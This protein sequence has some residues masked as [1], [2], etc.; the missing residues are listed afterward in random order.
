MKRIFAI[1]A[2]VVL[3]SALACISHNV[4]H[5]TPSEDY[6]HENLPEPHTYKEFV[7]VEGHEW[8]D[9]VQ[10]AKDKYHLIQALDASRRL[11]E[12]LTQQRDRAREDA[13]REAREHAETLEHARSLEQVAGEMNAAIKSIQRQ[14]RLTIAGT[15]IGVSGVV[16]FIIWRA[17]E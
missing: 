15:V 7:Y 16:T 14:R 4:A 12:E 13:D 11:N 10:I 17:V 8:R 6:A 9:V 2:Y 1:I 5:S 3:G